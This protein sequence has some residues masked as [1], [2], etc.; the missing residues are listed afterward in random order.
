M[1]ETKHVSCEV[2]T[3]LLNSYCLD[4]LESSISWCVIVCE[5]I[6]SSALAYIAYLYLCIA[7]LCVCNILL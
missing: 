6:F 5:S 2:E 7:T 1:K 4:E 3:K